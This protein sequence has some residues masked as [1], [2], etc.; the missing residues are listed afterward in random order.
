MSVYAHGPW[1]FAV[2]G[3]MSEKDHVIVPRTREGRIAPLPIVERERS[4]M[5]PS[6][7][8]DKI[9]DEKLHGGYNKIPTC[10][11]CWLKHRGPCY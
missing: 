4:S 7:V 10:P 3:R 1:G 2:A 6:W 11:S 8:L 9:A 5:P